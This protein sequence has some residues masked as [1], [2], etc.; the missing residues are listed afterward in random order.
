MK[1]LEEKSAM[2]PA[3]VKGK[4][5]LGCITTNIASTLGEATLCLCS[6]HEISRLGSLIQDINLVE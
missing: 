3:A 6:A 2:C 4:H 5:I 1:N